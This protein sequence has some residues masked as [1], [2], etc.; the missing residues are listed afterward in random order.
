M[1][2]A[3]FEASPEKTSRSVRS[4]L[5]RALLLSKRCKQGYKH[6][7]AEIS[8]VLSNKVVDKQ[9]DGALSSFDFLIQPRA[10]TNCARG[11]FLGTT[12]LQFVV[13]TLGNTGE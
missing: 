10:V 7:V 11:D 13:D 2:I 4:S 12:A 8:A 9:G 1:L 5:N 3:I 6:L